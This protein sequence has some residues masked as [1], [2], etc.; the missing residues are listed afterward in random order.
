[1][2]R[3]PSAPETVCLLG[4]TRKPTKGDVGYPNNNHT[5]NI[6]GIHNGT[7]LNDDV[8]FWGLSMHRNGAVDS[9]QGLRAFDNNRG[10]RK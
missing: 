2:P 5:K 8:L 4:H 6:I 3:E 1:M 7:I 10:S 9:E